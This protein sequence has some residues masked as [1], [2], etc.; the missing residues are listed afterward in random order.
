M[1]MGASHR[2][3]GRYCLDVEVIDRVSGKTFMYEDSIDK[4]KNVA[5]EVEG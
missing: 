5:V 2:F 3:N 4:L 1:T